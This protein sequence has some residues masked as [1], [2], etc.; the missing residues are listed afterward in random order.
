[1]CFGSLEHRVSDGTFTYGISSEEML[2]TL[3]GSMTPELA[4]EAGGSDECA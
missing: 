4:P 1:M 3:N 2:G